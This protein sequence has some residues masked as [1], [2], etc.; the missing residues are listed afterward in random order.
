[1]PTALSNA[2]PQ[3]RNFTAVKQISNTRSSVCCMPQSSQCHHISQ[4]V[5]QYP[6]RISH[7]RCERKSPQCISK[8]RHH[9]GS[10]SQG[11]YLPSSFFHTHCPKSSIKWHV[12]Q[13]RT[14]KLRC[15]HD[16]GRNIEWC[17]LYR[18][19]YAP[20]TMKEDCVCGTRDME[21]KALTSLDNKARNE[22]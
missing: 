8:R 1:M 6:T 15:R 17:T 7:Y 18:C 19:R 20:L 13:H 16:S 9:N 3:T 10:Q 2:L 11:I 22:L 4:Y 12:S 21:P 14:F 5:V